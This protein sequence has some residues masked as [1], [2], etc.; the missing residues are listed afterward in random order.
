MA[1]SP[2][3]F[4]PPHRL[5]EGSLILP[6]EF[7]HLASRAAVDQTLARL[8]REGKL[9]RVVRGAYTKPLTSRFGSRPPPPCTFCIPS[10]PLKNG[11]PCRPPG[12]HFPGGWHVPSVR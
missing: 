11:P 5:P 4:C 7:L 8:A 6:K 3:P 12:R 2:K 10:C 9:L 1:I